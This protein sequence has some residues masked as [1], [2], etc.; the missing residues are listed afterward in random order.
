MKA[1]RAFPVLVTADV[2]ASPL[3]DFA[4]LQELDGSHIRN[5]LDP[6]IRRRL[7][8]PVRL[9]INRGD[10]SEDELAQ[11]REKAMADPNIQN[12][13]TDPVMR[14]A[15]LTCPACH[16]WQLALIDCM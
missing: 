2:P 4:G 14:Q 8:T 7:M 12:I 15:G 16:I 9:Q 3:P 1:E 10:V 5:A 6:R 13:L 11:R